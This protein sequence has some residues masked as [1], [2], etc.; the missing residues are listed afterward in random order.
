MLVLDVE[1]VPKKQMGHCLMK[2]IRILVIKD[3]RV[4][5]EGLSIRGEFLAQQQFLQ[6]NQDALALSE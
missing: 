4:S 2:K 5:R 3:N 1:V 6:H